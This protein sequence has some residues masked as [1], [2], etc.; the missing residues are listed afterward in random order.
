MAEKF[1]SGIEAGGG[2]EQRRPKGFEQKVAELMKLKVEAENYANALADFRD[3]A[4]GGDGQGSRDS[5][6]ADW[7]DG[8]FAHLLQGLGE[9]DYDPDMQYP[10]PLPSDFEPTLA[11]QI[12]RKQKHD[13]Y[14]DTLRDYQE[15]A[16]GGDASG[17]RE[18]YPG[19]QDEDFAEL[20]E[21]F[22][23]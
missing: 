12:Q 13:L 2:A 9:D 7:Q 23:D 14:A 4:E 22:Q 15:M 17:V 6:Y 20:V 5:Y 11:V 8:H 10:E 18:A 1:F 21:L 3:M 16:E 19:W